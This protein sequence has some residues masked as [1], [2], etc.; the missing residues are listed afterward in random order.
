MILYAKVGVIAK[1]EETGEHFSPFHL[2]VEMQDGEGAWKPCDN[3]AEVNVTEGWAI[4]LHA[5][6]EE[7]VPGNYRITVAK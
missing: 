3:C 5:G 6:E 2:K 4:H 7:R 1:D